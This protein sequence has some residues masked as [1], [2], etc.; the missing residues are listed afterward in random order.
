MSLIM[1]KLQKKAVPAHLLLRKS[2]RLRVWKKVKGLWKHR[3]P[4]PLKELR[5]LR[6][7]WQ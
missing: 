1:T 4:E 5:M 6:E 2:E 7:E 3:K